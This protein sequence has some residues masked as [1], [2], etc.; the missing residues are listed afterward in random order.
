MYADNCVGVSLISVMHTL[1]SF[2]LWAEPI[3]TEPNRTELN[4]AERVTIPIASR[5][6][7]N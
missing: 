6:D 1:A 2:T 3:R 7:P 5:A 4:R